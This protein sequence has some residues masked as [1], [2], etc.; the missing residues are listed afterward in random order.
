MDAE[1]QLLRQLFF[2]LRQGDFRQKNTL[3]AEDFNVII[4]C[5]QVNNA[6]KGEAMHFAVGTE[7][8]EATVLPAVFQNSFLFQAFLGTFHGYLKT[9]WRNGFEQII[10][11]RQL[12]TLHCVLRIC[13]GKHHQRWLAQLAQYIQSTDVWKVDIQKQKIRL[14]I[15]QCRNGTLGRMVHTQTSPLGIFLQIP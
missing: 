13:G 14:L 11:C 5:L 10:Q 12:E 7:A 3:S 2:Q 15:F 4:Q 8:Q 9:I 6:L 1:K